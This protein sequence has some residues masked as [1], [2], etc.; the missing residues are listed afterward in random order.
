MPKYWGEQ[1][2][3]LGSFS[4]VGQKQKTEK[5]ER[6]EKRERLNDGNGQL[7]IAILLSFLGYLK[8]GVLNMTTTFF[9]LPVWSSSYLLKEDSALMVHA[10][11]QTNLLYK[12]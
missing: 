2:F 6:R 11:A 8:T 3:S 12:L 1:I 4:E 7:R 10:L 5:K 9:Q